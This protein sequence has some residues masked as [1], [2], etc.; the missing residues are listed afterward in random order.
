MQVEEL[1]RA[2]KIWEPKYVQRHG[3][4]I[5]LDWPGYTKRN[6]QRRKI[7]WDPET[8]KKRIDTAKKK[9]RGDAS[10]VEKSWRRW[11]DGKYEERG[12]VAERWRIKIGIGKTIREKKEEA[13]KKNRKVLIKGAVTSK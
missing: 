4:I 7:D 1:D 2:N 13:E 11:R 5:V 12:G 3:K 8:R 9:I 6:E 10:Y